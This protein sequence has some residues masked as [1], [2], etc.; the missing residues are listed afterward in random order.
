M[1]ECSCV[2]RQEISSARCSLTSNLRSRRKSSQKHRDT[3]KISFTRNSLPPPRNE[4]KFA[5]QASTLRPVCMQKIVW[6][7]KWDF[8]ETVSP[9]TNFCS[10]HSASFNCCDS[11]LLYIKRNT[12][13]HPWLTRTG[14]WA[15]NNHVVL[16]SVALVARLGDNILFGAGQSC[17]KWNQRCK[18]HTSTG[19]NSEV[20][21][22]WHIHSK[23]LRPYHHKTL[24]SQWTEVWLSIASCMKKKK[25]KKKKKMNMLFK[26]FLP[27]PSVV[28]SSLPH[29]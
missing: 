19:T 10:S 7:L 24:T 14:V 15:H 28:K 20:S 26:L 16:G 18:S 6:S 21:K 8:C 4:Q 9:Q 2:F 12:I 23:C 29:L 13:R 1:L 22:H 25:K 17:R 11:P 5:C 27:T 3:I